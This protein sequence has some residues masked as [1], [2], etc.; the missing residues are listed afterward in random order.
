MPSHLNVTDTVAT[1]GSLMLRVNRSANAGQWGRRKTGRR[2][3]RLPRSACSSTILRQ[4]TRADC[5]AS[6]LL[7]SQSLERSWFHCG[8]GSK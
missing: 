1:S 7:Q 5:S 6:S 2:Q 8:V 3:D 4:P